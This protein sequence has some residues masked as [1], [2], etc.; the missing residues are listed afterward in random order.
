MFTSISSFLLLSLIF[1]KTLSF[2]LIIKTSKLISTP[3]NYEKNNSK[4]TA[5]TSAV[6]VENQVYDDIL[7]KIELIES[8]MKRIEKEKRYSDA[9]RSLVFKNVIK[10]YSLDIPNLLKKL[11]VLKNKIQRKYPNI[12]LLYYLKDFL[13]SGDDYEKLKSFEKSLNS[14]DYQESIKATIKELIKIRFEINRFVQEIDLAIISKRSIGEFY[15]LSDSFER[16]SQILESI[17][18]DILKEFSDLCKRYG[19]VTDV[20]LR[21]KYEILKIIK[22]YQSMQDLPDEFQNFILNSI[23]INLDDILLQKL[24]LKDVNLAGVN[25]IIKNVMTSGIFN[26]AQEKAIKVLADL[27][28]TID[29]LICNEIELEEFTSNEQ[30][31][32]IAQNYMKINLLLSS[33]KIFFEF[34]K[35]IRRIHN[36]WMVRG[37]CDIESR[38]IKIKWTKAEIATVWYFRE[39]LIPEYLTRLT[40]NFEFIND[41]EWPNEWFNLK[42]SERKE[43]VESKNFIKMIEKQ[44]EV[45]MAKLLIY[46]ERLE[47]WF[48]INKAMGKLTEDNKSQVMDQLNLYR[49]NEIPNDLN[50]ILF[51]IFVDL[52]KYGLNEASEP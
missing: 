4:D 38:Q 48:N 17:L 30:L 31:V 37:Q 47:K 28:N 3:I 14:I 19:I 46:W 35:F 24:P 18:E 13:L 36:F 12:Y 39:K 33:N 11:E 9:N 5:E 25:L 45:N 22:K 23:V 8:R 1:L 40:I 51:R 32:I 52:K 44:V 6:H 29:R 7:R 20:F 26:F 50:K 49:E 15:L 27:I 42:E 10:E 41:P 16:D 21:K 34:F 2:F 43:A